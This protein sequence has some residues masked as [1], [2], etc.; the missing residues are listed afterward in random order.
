M[1]TSPCI[2]GDTFI[3]T[4]LAGNKFQYVHDGSGTLYD[5][6][7]I[8]ISDGIHD[9]A[10]SVDV[11]VIRVDQSAPHLLPSASCRLVVKEGMLN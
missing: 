1:K 11:R 10:A 3:Y 4:D 5:T 2:A 8:S 9:T 7:Q 6:M